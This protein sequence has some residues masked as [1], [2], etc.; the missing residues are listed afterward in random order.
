MPLIKP[1]WDIFKAKFSND[2][3]VS[4]EWLCY[5]LVCKEFNLPNG[6]FRYLNQS[7]METN[8]ITHDKKISDYLAS[9]PRFRV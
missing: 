9:R 1:D 6:I 3:N 2:P 4:F 5:L 7:G 8:P